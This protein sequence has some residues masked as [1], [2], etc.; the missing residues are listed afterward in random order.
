MGRRWSGDK[1]LSEPTSDNLLYICCP[2][3]DL[4]NWIWIPQT[5]IPRDRP[6]SNGHHS[7]HGLYS[8]LSEIH[9]FGVKLITGLCQLLWKVTPGGYANNEN[10][11]IGKMAYLYIE[12]CPNNQTFGIKFNFSSTSSSACSIVTLLRKKRLP[13][14]LQQHQNTPH[15]EHAN[16]DRNVFKMLHLHK[17]R[18]QSLNALRAGKLTHCSI[19]MPYGDIGLGNDLWL[20]HYLNQC[21]HT[22]LLQHLNQDGVFLKD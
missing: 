9:N 21:W 6:H 3:V 1:S 19:V 15:T 5:L 10:L 16:E 2:H 20:S 17:H 8:Q 4:S 12:P 18:D 11:Y 22:T 14:D 7:P 13:L